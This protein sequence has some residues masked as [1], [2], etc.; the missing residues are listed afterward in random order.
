MYSPKESPR[1]TPS[2][3]VTT[4]WATLILSSRRVLNAPGD[5][6]DLAGVE[7]LQD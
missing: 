2:Q 4:G 7:A 5:L 6:L 1:P 3:T